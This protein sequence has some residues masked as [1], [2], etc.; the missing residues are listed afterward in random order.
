[1]SCL[2]AIGQMTLGGRG[3]WLNRRLPTA[4]HPG[5]RDAQAHGRQGRDRPSSSHVEARWPPTLGP[6]AAFARHDCGNHLSTAAKVAVA[7]AASKQNKIKKWK[8]CPRRAARRTR[9]E[10]ARPLLDTA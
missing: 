4:L 9:R 1:M 8:G 7:A 2:L 3:R 10:P 6:A 5:P